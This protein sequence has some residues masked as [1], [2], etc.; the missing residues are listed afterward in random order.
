MDCSLI[1]ASIKLIIDGAPPV[2]HDAL[3]LPDMR[4]APVAVACKATLP[5]YLVAIVVA[6]ARD[7]LILRTAVIQP[8]KKIGEQRAVRAVPMQSGLVLMRLQVYAL[9]TQC[10]LRSA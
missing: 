9:F 3:Q 8:E 4:D 7:G 1:L 10:T 2:I 5:P 6:G